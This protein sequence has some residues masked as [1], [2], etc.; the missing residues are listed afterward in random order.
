MVLTSAK[1]RVG[2]DLDSCGFVAFDAA[3]SADV[4]IVLANYST[5]R[6]TIQSKCLVLESNSNDK[7]SFLRANFGLQLAFVLLI[8]NCC[9]HAIFESA[10]E[11]VNFLWTTVRDPD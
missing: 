8:L 11:S 9:L 7:K 5:E 4:A 6:G 3:G 1:R 2:K 10:L